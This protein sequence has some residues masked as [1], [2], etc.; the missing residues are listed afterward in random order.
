MKDIKEGREGTEALKD[1]FLVQTGLIF[2]NILSVALI[3][4]C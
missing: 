4:T 2:A 3:F 1:I